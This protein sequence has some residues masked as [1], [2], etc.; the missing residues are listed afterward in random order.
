MGVEAIKILNFPF[1][2]LTHLSKRNEYRRT[3]DFKFPVHLGTAVYFDSKHNK[4]TLLAGGIWHNDPNMFLKNHLLLYINSEV[5]ARDDK[6]TRVILPL[7]G[8]HW[9]PIRIPDVAVCA[10]PF[11]FQCLVLMPL[12]PWRCLSGMLAFQLEVFLG[13]THWSGSGL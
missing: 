1:K 5:S 10:F 12:V 6:I 8:N 2:N 3:R 13:E 7:A 9:R 4:T 11:V